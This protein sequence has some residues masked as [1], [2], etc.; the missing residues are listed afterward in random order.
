MSILI[1]S[2]EEGVTDRVEA[3]TDGSSWSDAD[4]G[5]WPLSLSSGCSPA[6]VCQ[7][8]P[9]KIGFPGHRE[10]GI[11][12]LTESGAIYF[13]PGREQMA[14]R[15]GVKAIIQEEMQEAQRRMQTYRAGRPPLDLHGKTAIIVDDGIAT[16]VTM[17]AALVSAKKAG[18]DRT[19]VAV[20]VGPPDAEAELRAIADDVLI[21]ETPYPF[22]AVGLWYQVRSK[23]TQ[24]RH[25]ERNQ[26]NELS[27]GRRCS[28]VRLHPALAADRL[29]SHCCVLL[30][31]S[32]LYAMLRTGIRWRSDWQAAQ[33]RV[34]FG[35]HL[36]LAAAE[37]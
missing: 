29:A 10:Y 5:R 1:W 15:D 19:L 31:R 20:P 28:R 14:Q 9:R 17:R 16:G 33:G 6:L 32:L 21:L 12:A 27:R 35:G 11:G 30:G 26:R 18:A 7:V 24:S 23:W 36:L 4:G 3:L 25:A 22:Q 2:D 37:L 13:S 34:K 8:V